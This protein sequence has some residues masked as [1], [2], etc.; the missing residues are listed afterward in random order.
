MS[1]REWKVLKGAACYRSPDF[2]KFFFLEIACPD[3]EFNW[4]FIADF[5]KAS[6]PGKVILLI[7]VCHV[8]TYHHNT[9]TKCQCWR[10]FKNTFLMDEVGC[11]LGVGMTPPK[12][13]VTVAVSIAQGASLLI[14]N[15]TRLQGRNVAYFPYVE[16][17]LWVC[18]CTKTQCK[19]KGLLGRTLAVLN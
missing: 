3:D 14:I 4:V 9:V 15:Y 1:L 7:T 2:F 5:N 6:R 13:F 16:F 18:V 8:T 19:Q 12:K 10:N 11:S 17:T